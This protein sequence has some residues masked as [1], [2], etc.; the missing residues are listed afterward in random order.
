[1]KIFKGKKYKYIHTTDI[2]LDDLRAV[3]FPKGFN[4]KYKYLGSPPWEEK[5]EIFPA[6]LPLVLLMDYYAKRWWTP[7]W[8]LRLLHLFGNDNSIVRVRNFSL[9]NLHRKLTRGNLFV[10]YK[11]KWT[12]YDLR[13]SVY[14]ND[15]VQSLADDIERTFY[16]KGR[17][18][19][20]I[21]SL[22]EHNIKYEEWESLDKLEK[23]WEKYILS[24]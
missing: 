8:F 15:T 10:D 18:E 20:I 14:G 12:P 13:I 17:K 19:D 22:K 6:L 21:K 1:M 23:I 4:E 3:F 7:R 9:H 24:S 16:R 2:M 11:T 5:G